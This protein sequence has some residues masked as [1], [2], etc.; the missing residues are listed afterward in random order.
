MEIQRFRGALLG[1]AILLGMAVNTSAGDGPVAIAIH[2]GAGTINKGELSSEKEAAIRASLAEALKSGHE[3][4]TAGGS[5]LDAVETAIVILEDSPH[6]NAGHGAVFAA[7]GGNELDASIMDG[8]T[9]NAGAVAGV[10]H[11]RNPIRLARKVMSESPHVMLSGAGA[12]EFALKHGTELV[13]RDYFHTPERWEQLR[14]AR[15]LMTSE[16]ATLPRELRLGTVGAV[17]LDSNGNLAA[18]TSTGGMTNK[19]FGRIGDSPVI[20]AGTYASND[21][22]A[23]SATGHGEYF[24]RAVVAHDIAARMRYGNATLEESAERVVMSD[25]VR[26]GGDGGIVALDAKGTVVMKHNT[27]GMYRGYIDASGRSGVAIYAGE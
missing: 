19:R 27:P 9:R 7:D 26:M 25:L 1:A 23:V 8:A 13:P 3:V 24:I 14:K 20:G 5:A 2:G 21:T 18:G 12:E 4:L 17:A 15:E 11:V 10:R 16:T 22:C 6:F